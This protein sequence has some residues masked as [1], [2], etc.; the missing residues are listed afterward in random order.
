MECA[1]DESSKFRLDE[2]EKRVA[3]M[4]GCGQTRVRRFCTTE[5][6]WDKL[7]EDS[8]RSECDFAVWNGF[9]N[10]PRYV[11]TRFEIEYVLFFEAK[12]IC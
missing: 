12:C 9:G 8:E 1:G 7:I 4:K 2:A 5:W 10:S 3:R 6:H 11:C